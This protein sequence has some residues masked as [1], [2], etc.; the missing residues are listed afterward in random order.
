MI[1]SMDRKEAYRRM[2]KENRGAWEEDAVLLL[3]KG[4]RGFFRLIF[5]RTTVVILLLAAQFILLFIGFYHLRDYT[6]YGGSMLVGLVVALMVVNRKG[7]PAA[8]LTW[9]MLIMLFPI[10]A[11]PFYLFV[12]M[13]WGHRLTRARLEEIGKKTTGFLPER[14]EDME[15]LAE[16]DPGAAG[17]AS[18]LGRMGSHPAYRNSGAVYYP[19]GEKAF[20][21]MLEALESAKDYVQRRTDPQLSGGEVDRADGHPAGADSA[22]RGER[23]QHAGGDELHA[24][25]AQ[26]AGGGRLY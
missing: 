22:R 15:A 14:P 10:F 21:A 23:L 3:N 11:V 25:P 5:G 6:Y 17:L 9:I 12:N 19:V 18:Y 20:A 8:K 1:V 4:K 24:Q 2:A 7:N 16:A 26:G 13:E